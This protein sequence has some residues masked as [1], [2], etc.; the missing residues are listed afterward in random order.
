MDYTPG[1]FRNVTPAQFEPRDVGPEVMTTR[2]QQL[3]MYVVYLSPFA[4]LADAPG[5]YE[6]ADFKPVPG[7]DFLKIVPTTWDETRAIAGEFGHYIVV[8]RRKGNQW[9]VGAMNDETARS[10]TIPLDFLGSGKWTAD[11]WIDGAA[12]N[13]VRTGHQ[14][15][16]TRT[17][18]L[19]LASGG[20][21][22]LVLTAH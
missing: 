21:A 16:S 9:F 12:P 6:T 14:P 19:N 8:A 3:A 13:E 20:G 18:T 4:C 2:A 22:A 10:V 7:A 17:M 15:V 5:A 1:G 11:S